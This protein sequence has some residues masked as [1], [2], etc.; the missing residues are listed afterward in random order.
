MLSDAMLPHSF[1]YL[2]LHF[3]ANVE[4]HKRKRR[5]MEPSESILKQKVSL[6]YE[7]RSAKFG[8]SKMSI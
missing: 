5:E 6:V 7:L 3:G 1:I 2:V 4:S 8:G